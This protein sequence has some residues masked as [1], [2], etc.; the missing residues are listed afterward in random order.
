[1]TTTREVQVN[2]PTNPYT[3]RI[4][5]NVLSRVG[6]LASSLN[7][8]MLCAVITDS[9]VA[10]L[11]AEEVVESLRKHGFLPKLFEVQAGEA[12]KSFKQV[13]ALCEQMIWAGMD[14]TS[15]ILALGGGVIGDLA[16]FVAAI[17][18]RGIPYIQLPTTIMAQVDS[19]VGGKTGVNASSGKN[20]IGA[21]HQPLAVLTD[22]KT[23]GTLPEREYHEGFAEIIKHAA[24]R[25][26]EFFEKLKHFDKNDIESII[27]RNVEIKAEIVAADERETTGE[28]A[29]LNFGHTIG[30]AIE[31]A[32]GYGHYLHGEAISLGIAGALH[33]SV[34]LG[35]LSSAESEEALALLKKFHLPTVSPPRIDP[36]KIM[37][38]LKKDKKFLGGQVRFVLLS[39]IGHAF[40]SDDVTIQDIE[41]TL[42]NLSKTH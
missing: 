33:L 28:R 23:L 16:G 1:M 27:Q 17:Y 7:L 24:I 2:L 11:Y 36:R 31:N 40:V 21:F 25:D 9:N 26:R 13:E 42:K 32:A 41:D 39:S 20:L 10:P 35:G 14:R 15:F 6:K 22:V 4:G 30:H 38:A 37:Q 12:S 19:S 29:L 3:V 8:G 34:A 18:F 5:K